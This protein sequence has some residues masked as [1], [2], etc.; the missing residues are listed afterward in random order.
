M[1]NLTAPQVNIGMQVVHT[2][3][4]RVRLKTC[5]E[6][7]DIPTL[8]TIV[9]QLQQ[10]EGIYEVKLNDSTGSIVVSFDVSTMSLS[11]LWEILEDLNIIGDRTPSLASPTTETV[12]SKSPPVNATVK[13]AEDLI[14]SLVPMIACMLVNQRLRISGW[15]ALPVSLVTSKLT[16]RVM[17]QLKAELGELSAQK[18]LTPSLT[19]TIT[20][21]FQV[22][23][24]T[25]GRVRLRVPQLAKDADY[26]HRLEQLIL[27]TDG[28][29]SVR[30][31]RSAASVAIAYQS[32]LDMLPYLANLLQEANFNAT[33]DTSNN[34][35]ADTELTASSQ[36]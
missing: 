15:Q 2:T 25:P 24:S 23:H 19:P 20:P 17:G 3:P 18:N 32:H 35:S 30:V 9:Q 13:L 26:G 11:R 31:N 4:G 27:T 8:K 6:N 34:N 10:Q 5:S 29:T 21:S 22:V 33:N 1:A 36:T 28:V 14:D 7:I 12:E 16:R